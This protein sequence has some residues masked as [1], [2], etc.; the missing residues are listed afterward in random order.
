M[1]KLTCAAVGV[2]VVVGLSVFSGLESPSA[3]LPTA[4]GQ[5]KNAESGYKPVVP[6]DIL[7]DMVSDGYDD[8]LDQI[9]AKKFSKTRKAAYAVAEYMNIAQYHWSEEVK[10]KDRAK[11]KTISLA[12]RGEMLKAAQLAKKK[13]LAGVSKI[14]KS[15]EDSCESCHDLRE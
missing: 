6:I 3:P 11:W 8:I 9:K 4:T 13:D 10:E 2:A 15:V 1:Q 14:L 7:M 5:A 12:I